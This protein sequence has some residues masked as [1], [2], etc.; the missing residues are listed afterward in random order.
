MAL[1]SAES[2]RG[3]VSFRDGEWEECDVVNSNQQQISLRLASGEQRTVNRNQCQFHYRNP[4]AVE[5]AEDFLTLPNLDEP[6]ILHSLRV[7]YWKGIV[8][9]YTGPILIAVN[10]WRSV[11][12]Y[13]INQLEAYK[14][15]KLKS[16]H[17]FGVATKAFK[18]L[19]ANRKNQCI[20]IS[21]ESGAGKT[22]STKYVLQ[23]LTVAGDIRTGASASIEQQ[24]MLTNPG[25]PLPVPAHAV[26]V[27]DE[28]H[29]F[30]AQ[31]LPC[32]SAHM[33]SCFLSPCV[34][35]LATLSASSRC[36]QCWRRLA[37]PRP[38]ATTILRVSANGSMSTLT[39][40]AP[41]QVGSSLVSRDGDTR[42]TPN[43]PH[44][45][46]SPSTQPLKQRRNSWQ[47]R[48]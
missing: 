48:A 19:M 46:A 4:S 36:C 23:V 5:S 39:A 40:R 37:M 17:I 34:C 21:G 6:N 9:S 14:A 24:V 18:D 7:R 2:N 8:Y 27:H 44:P 25:A 42:L 13:N 33:S 32:I 41:L 28:S 38:C 22:E 45:H 29:A 35:A 31:G 20:L 26:A 1:Y 30:P 3:W 16:P 43:H 47:R 10:P 12:I 15:G 11:D